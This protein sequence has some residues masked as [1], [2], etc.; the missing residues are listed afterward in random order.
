MKRA[1]PRAIFDRSA[2]TMDLPLTGKPRTARYAYVIAAVGVLIALLGWALSSL[3]HS[4]TAA[5]V[6]KSTLVM[7]VARSGTLLRSVSAQGAF[8]PERVRVTSATQT[9][10]VNQ[11]FVKAG[12]T[13]QPGDII[14]QMQNPELDAQV[15][16]ARSALQVAQANLASARQQAKA[17]IISQQVAV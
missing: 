9:G 4:Q 17:N 2:A 8:A 5:V 6:D 10:V 11:V 16:N 14:A 1:R 3:T 13:V 7:D 12:S 15:V